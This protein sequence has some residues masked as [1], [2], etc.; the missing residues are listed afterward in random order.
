MD[1]YTAYTVE[2]QLYYGYEHCAFSLRGDNSL[3]QTH[4]YSNTVADLYLIC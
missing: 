2:S 4:I 3:T 1:V